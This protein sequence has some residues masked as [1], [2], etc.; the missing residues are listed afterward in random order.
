[1]LAILQA[2]SAVA[3][4]MLE[5]S[6]GHSSIILYGERPGRPGSEG[7]TLIELLV[8]IAVIAILASLLLPVL[9]R[10]K[11]AAE[12]TLCASNMRQWG[13]AL[14]CYATDCQDSFPDATETD[15][16]WAGPKLQKF[17]A[18]YLLKQA[19][20]AAKPRNNVIHC[21]TQKWHRFYSEP[22]FANGQMV[23][24]GYQYLPGRDTNSP[25]WNYNTHG[26]GGWA[27]KKKFH[28]EYKKAPLLI[29]IMQ[30]IGGYNGDTPL[31]QNWFYDTGLPYSSHPLPVGRPKGGNFLF[32]DGRVTWY[33]FEKIG[34]GSCT[35]A[36]VVYYKIPLL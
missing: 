20:G 21:P 6:Q 22:D 5:R 2:L 31:Q 29:D 16:N 12:K 35:A 14:Q 13:I 32:E 18:D 19:Q 23:I 24:I 33:P 1:M 15:L 10:G 3:A 30:S 11:L 27:G 25:Y 28:R 36:W 17:W 8:V 26:L 34:I 7:F 9:S 4:R